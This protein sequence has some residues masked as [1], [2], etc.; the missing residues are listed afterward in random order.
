MDAPPQVAIKG[1]NASDAGETNSAVKDNG[2]DG[3]AGLLLHE[4]HVEVATKE[5]G[6]ICLEMGSQ[7]LSNY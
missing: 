6:R 2:R 4:T 7:A 3:M 1:E 5:T